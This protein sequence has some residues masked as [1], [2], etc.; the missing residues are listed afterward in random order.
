MND[1]VYANLS[2]EE[3]AREILSHISAPQPQQDL[4]MCWSDDLNVLRE[5]VS[6]VIE[7][8]TAQKAY[9]KQRKFSDLERA[10]KAELKVDA[11][12][13]RNGVQL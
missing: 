10:K 11:L 9:F 8:R 5:I 13:K 2:G 7:M 1:K 4:E 6:A 3:R 12:L